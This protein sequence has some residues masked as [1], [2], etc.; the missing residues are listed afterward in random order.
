MSL[1]HWYPHDPK[2]WLQRCE[3]LSLTERGALQYVLDVSWG[4][5]PPCTIADTAAEF[6]RLL[7]SDH[8]RL[9]RVIQQHFTPDS[10]HPGRLRCEWLSAIHAEQ[11]RAY[12]AR[13]KGG[14]TRSGEMWARDRLQKQK[15]QGSLF[16]RPKRPRDSNAIGDS[17]ATSSATAEQSRRR[18]G[19]ALLGLEVKKY[20]TPPTPPES[21]AVAAAPCAPAAPAD[22]WVGPGTD[23]L[24][25]WAEADA[26]IADAVAERVTAL[27]AH[28]P[29]GVRVP[30]LRALLEEQALREEYDARHSTVEAPAS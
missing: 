4:H 23:E 1:L 11:T 24:R 21:A 12:L 6:E 13:R 15:G 17:S 2:V 14:V 20:L 29:T 8:H 5:E 9:Q 26:A 25:A 16:S 27:S 28:I 19:I 30:V 18:G 22:G 3:G 7:G 10:A